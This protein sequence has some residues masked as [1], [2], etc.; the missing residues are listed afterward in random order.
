MSS[1][2][3]GPRHSTLLCSP[4]HPLF[5]LPL[6]W[7]AKTK[8]RLFTLSRGDIFVKNQCVL[9]SLQLLCKEKWELADDSWVVRNRA[10]GRSKKCWA[11]EK[12]KQQED[13]SSERIPG[14]SNAQGSNPKFY[15]KCLCQLFHL[16]INSPTPR[17]FLFWHLLK[18]A[19]HFFFFFITIY[20][21]NFLF[22]AARHAFQDLSKYVVDCE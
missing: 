16:P 10:R 12:L 19:L 21:A 18:T 20:L 15:R 3:S 5:F 13:G 22:A 6:A 2:K 11:S 8:C 9:W 7:L 4:C 17:C 1:L 14:H